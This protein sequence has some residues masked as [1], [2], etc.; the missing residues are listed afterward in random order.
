MPMRLIEF[1]NIKNPDVAGQTFG[2][3]LPLF[4]LNLPHIILATQLIFEY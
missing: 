4:L 2:D 1:T 3:A